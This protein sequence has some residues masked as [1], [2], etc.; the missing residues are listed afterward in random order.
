MKRKIVLLLVSTMLLTMV[1]GGAVSAQERPEPVTLKILFF[2]DKPAHFDEVLDEFYKRTKDTLNVTLD[3]E[4]NPVPDHK[5]KLLLIA[6]AGEEYDLVFD[7][8]WMHI[9]KLAKDGAYLNLD[10]YFHNDD[11]PGLKKN[12]SKTYLDSNKFYGHTYGVP[13]TKELDSLEAIGIRSDL[14]EKYGFKEIKTTAKLKE[15]FDVILEKE[16]DLI[17]LAQ[18]GITGFFRLFPRYTEEYNIFRITDDN[19]VGRFYVALSED[20]KEV[21][22][23]YTDGDPAEVVKDFPAPWNTV[24]KWNE[25]YV[26]Y[27]EWNKYLEKDVLSQQ[28]PEMLYSS[29]KAAALARGGLTNSLDLPKLIPGV[30]SYPFPYRKG[31]RLR[32]P[33]S[34]YITYKVWNFACVPVTSNHPDRVMKF[35]DWIFQSRENHDL[36]EMGIKG[37]HWIPVGEERYK[38]PEGLEQEYKF[39][40]YELTGH[41]DMVRY[42]EL[43]NDDHISLN[44]W[45][46]SE[47][48]NVLSPLAGFT[49]DFEAVRTEKAGYDSIYKKIEVGIMNGA[50][51]DPVAILE[52][53]NS[54]A[55]KAGLEKIREELKKQVQ[56]FLDAKYK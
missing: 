56:A 40:W 41:P 46:S 12:F 31:D 16:P 45:A 25:K 33:D 51:Q 36:I 20:N 48:R 50:Y 8:P 7:A 30:E 23:V 18:G 43:Y 47:E 37:K 49:A 28:D 13:V 17:P 42:S 5:Q 10:K 2:N 11:Y 27:R 44:K 24:E 6:A 38:F 4:F 22:G 53:V 39:Q 54:D 26:K 1:V 29:G 3:F 55:R 32:I 52:K 19:F 9:E 21:T 34:K 14:M 35:I 15:F